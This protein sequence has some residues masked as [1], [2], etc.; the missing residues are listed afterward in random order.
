MTTISTTT[1]TVDHQTCS[2]IRLAC[3]SRDVGLRHAASDATDGLRSHMAVY[4]LRPR[5]SGT[6]HYRLSMV[7]KLRRATCTET[8]TEP[9]YML[10]NSS[11]ND[12]VRKVAH[13]DRT[14][15]MLAYSLL[16]YLGCSGSFT[17]MFCYCSKPALLHNSCME[18]EL[19][20]AGEITIHTAD[21]LQHGLR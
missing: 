2:T 6:F 1:C 12:T 16:S 21:C 3:Q 9:L 14:H 18:V 20:L 17:S 5:A 11:K 10:S 13:V 15:V 7:S 19:P 4:V 8:A